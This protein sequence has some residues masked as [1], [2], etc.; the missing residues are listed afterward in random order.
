V[1][2]RPF[3]D[4]R[5]RRALNYAIDR[6]HMAGLEGGRGLA[7]LTCQVIPPGLPGY[8]P[9]CPFTRDPSPGGGWSAP[10]LT[11]AHRL[12]AA[13]GTRGARVQMWG[14]EGA[15]APVSRYTGEVLRGLGYRVSVRLLP[16]SRYFQYVGDSRNHVQ[17]G[18]GGWS[19]DFL[20]PSSF[21][22][23]TLTCAQ[24][25]RRSAVNNNLSQFCDHRLD[26]AYDAALAAHGGEANAGWVAVDRRITAASPLIPLYNRRTV[27]LVSDRVGNVQMHLQLGPLLDQAW[28]H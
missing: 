10:D 20:T 16:I 23:P 19:A 7:G 22:G 1:R 28:V 14:L 9:A 3:D 27:M 11:R 6:R 4:P 8:V 24:L 15:Y 18:F 2:E 26:A 5:V 21:F 12:I 17:V 25:L 13:S